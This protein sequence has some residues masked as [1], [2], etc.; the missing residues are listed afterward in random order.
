MDSTVFYSTCEIHE[1]GAVCWLTL[2][3]ISNRPS[4][5]LEVQSKNTRGSHLL[6]KNTNYGATLSKQLVNN[7]YQLVPIKIPRQRC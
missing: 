2:R 7:S 6:S 5:R 4:I 1:Q 3:V